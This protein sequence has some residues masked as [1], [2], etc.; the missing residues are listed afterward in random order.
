MEIRPVAAREQSTTSQSGGSLAAPQGKWSRTI[1]QS[2]TSRPMLQ[3]PGSPSVGAP[4]T[5]RE[6]RPG[7]RKCP[8][9]WSDGSPPSTQPSQPSAPSQK[10]D[11]QTKQDYVR[12][13]RDLSKTDDKKSKKPKAVKHTRMPL[14]TERR[15]RSHSPKRRREG[16]SPVSGDT[17]EKRFKLCDARGAGTKETMT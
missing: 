16:D 14:F 8:T 3:T 13:G 11:G 17:M 10:T 7:V 15:S 5:Q 6:R 9:F 12:R 4:R 1:P 2:G